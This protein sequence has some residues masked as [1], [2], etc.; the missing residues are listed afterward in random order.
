MV[1]SYDPDL[2]AMLTGGYSCSGCATGMALGAHVCTGI[3][4]AVASEEAARVTAEVQSREVT[5][6]LASAAAN[7]AALRSA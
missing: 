6:M 5:A 3:A 1:V 4:H 7:R 2:Y